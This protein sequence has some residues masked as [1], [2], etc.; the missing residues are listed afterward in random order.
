MLQRIA[1]EEGAL[2][3]V[4]TTLVLVSKSSASVNSYFVR[5]FRN[6][7]P[8]CTIRSLTYETRDVRDRLAVDRLGSSSLCLSCGAK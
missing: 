8:P 4:R 1:P 3:A 2:Q 6:I 5:T 7:T